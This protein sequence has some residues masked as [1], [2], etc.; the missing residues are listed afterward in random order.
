ME[1][2]HWPPRL[3]PGSKAAPGHAMARIIGHACQARS[4]NYSSN[5][6]KHHQALMLM[7]LGKRI[8]LR[9]DDAIG[10]SW[11]GL[12]SRE[13]GVIRKKLSMALRALHC[14]LPRG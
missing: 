8:F 3:V 7:A 10:G 5:S 4:F 14:G 9:A 13:S 1:L 11:E 6:S 12:S 2:S